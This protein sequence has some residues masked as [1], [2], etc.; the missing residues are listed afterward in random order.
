MA[1]PGQ[2]QHQG[3]GVG[4]PRIVPVLKMASSSTVYKQSNRR[5]RKVRL[6]RYLSAADCGEVYT[7]DNITLGTAADAA[8]EDA[9]AEDV[10]AVAAAD[11][12][13]VLL[14]LPAAETVS[15]NGASVTQQHKTG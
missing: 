6:T 10:V 13:T 3:C 12:G 11:A 14:S 9:A 4:V 8:A 1:V 15:T 5:R 2:A 7:S